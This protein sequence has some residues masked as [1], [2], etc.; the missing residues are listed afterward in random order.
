M[1]KKFLYVGTDGL[2][3]ESAGA[4]ESSEF[5]STSAGAGDSGKPVVLD[6]GG[7]ID[8]SMIDGGDVA[9]DDTSG[10]AASTGHTAFPLLD[11]TRPFTGNQSM[12]SN[13]LTNVADG[14]D[15]SDGINKSQLDAI[16]AGFDLKERCR[17]STN[18]ALPAYTPAGSGVGKTITMDAV[19][20]L[21]IDGIATVLGDRV[22]IKDEASAHVDHG[23]YD[24]TTEGTAGVAAVLTRSEDTDGNPA[25]EVSN[26]MFS[27]ILEGTE[28]GNSGWALIT[29]NPI[30]VDTTPLEFSQFQGLPK[31]TAS[32][33]VELVGLDFRADLLASGGI[34]LSGNEL[35][36]EPNDFAGE[37]MVDDGA[38][39]LAIDWSTAFNDSKAIK[40]SDLS[41]NDFSPG[42][43]HQ[44]T[45]I[46]QFYH[47]HV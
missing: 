31:Y 19:G 37:G 14:T 45:P 20:I 1:A 21:T 22:L 5:I 42:S 13:K 29:E 15:P 18:A 41:S 40:A 47:H 28:N 8:A 46:Y 7:Q 9:H 6:A 16:A 24:V 35:A 36:I 3:V 25:G 30:T 32:L 26:G 11:G 23:I 38:D 10:M 44:N 39:N 17:V 33:G 4:F 2:P 43:F 34:K 27:F 12:G